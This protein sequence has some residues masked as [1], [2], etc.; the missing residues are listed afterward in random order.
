MS[1]NYPAAL[2]DSSTLPN[3]SSSSAPNSPSHAG[4]HSNA[5][6]AIKATEAKVGTGASTPASNTLLI[7]TGTG[8]SAWSAL[9]SS[10]LAGV[11]SDETGTGSAV[12]A[13]TPTLVTPKV[14]TINENTLNN[15]VTVGGVNLK[16]GVISTSNAVPSAAIQTGAVGNTQLAVGIVVQV[17]STNYSAVATGTTL[18]PLDDTI[19]QITEGTEF[20][21]Q[22]I[23][24]KSVTN[25]L[26]IEA[27]LL[28]SSSASQTIIA[29]LFQDSN[30]NSLATT[31]MFQTT[32]TG[33][34]SIKL[35]HDMVAGTT[36]ATTFRVRVGTSGVST[37]TL[38]G[39]SSAR[40]FG[41]ITLSNIR[42]TEYKA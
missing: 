22:T 35:T 11:L 30:A 26:S 19:P 6:D 1:T 9:T 34:V 27:V 32:A 18:I 21:T 5:Q 10:Q 42:I 20:M 36:S 7:G 33:L 29:A 25:K 15:G 3:P 38:N 14:D 41:G 24:P 31:A 2:D 4:L 40:L 8:T 13:T 23:T 12:F 39:A 17:A 16:A 37:V 28:V